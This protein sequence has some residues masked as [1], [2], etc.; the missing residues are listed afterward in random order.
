[1]TKLKSDFAIIDIKTGRSAIKKRLSKGE[2]VVL[3]LRVE[4]YNDWRSWGNDDGES[5][6]FSGEVISAKEAEE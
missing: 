5:I 3:D 1:M 6:E 4:L 2:K